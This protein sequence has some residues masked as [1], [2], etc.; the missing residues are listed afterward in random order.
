MRK[1]VLYVTLILG[2]LSVPLLCPLSNAQA[3]SRISEL[4]G[5]WK[6]VEDP[7]ASLVVK[8]AKWISEYENKIQDSYKFAVTNNCLNFGG[9]PDPRGKFIVFPDDEDT[10]MSI[11]KLTENVLQ[12]SLVGRGNTLNYLRANNEQAAATPK[13]PSR[14]T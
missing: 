10:C 12:L 2:A 13:T 3:S 9:T 1:F 5:S 14:A 4:Q 7:N 8:G 11:V 6:S